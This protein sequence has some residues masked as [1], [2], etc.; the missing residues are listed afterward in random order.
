M[1]EL[2][3][4]S[5][6]ET[7]QQVMA[8]QA[9]VGEAPGDLPF[10]SGEVLTIVGK[11]DLLYWYVARNRGGDQGLVPRNFLEPVKSNPPQVPPK[12]KTSNDDDF[13]GTEALDMSLIEVRTA[14]SMYLYL[15]TCVLLVC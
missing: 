12:P 6:L 11:S 9:Y 4:S 3:E 15:N 7:N 2:P 8:I 13:T 5:P 1:A 10:G 14:Q